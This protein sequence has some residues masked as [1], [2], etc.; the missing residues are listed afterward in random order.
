MWAE[1]TAIEEAE[2]SRAKP[3]EGVWRL[4]SQQVEL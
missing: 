3:E 2:D 4:T 1:Q